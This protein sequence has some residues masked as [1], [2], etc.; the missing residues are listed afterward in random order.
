MR[1]DVHQITG[2]LRSTLDRL[3][4]VDFSAV[5][6]D[7]LGPLALEL[8]RERARLDAI[9]L[10]AVA[11]HDRSG[12]WADDGSRSSKGW[13]SHHGKLPGPVAG[14]LVRLARQQAAMPLVAAALQRGEITIEH[15]DVLARAR[16]PERA[17]IFAEHE[18]LLLDIATTMPFVDFRRAVQYWIQRVD[19]DGAEKR[20]RDRFA[21]R[22]LYPRLSQFCV[23][24]ELSGRLGS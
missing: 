22:A 9:W 14:R 3:E 4:Q 21:S 19:A 6:A 11:A 17:A 5:P 7:E 2:E 16:T 15:L 23:G 18:Q 1:C 20:R 12:V 24:G 13:L 10:K 8:G